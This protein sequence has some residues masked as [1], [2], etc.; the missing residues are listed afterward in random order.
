MKIDRSN[1]NLEKY[2]SIARPQNTA[3]RQGAAVSFEQE[4]IQKRHADNHLRMQELLKE[5]DKI[6]SQLNQALSIN[7]LMQYKKLVKNFLAEAINRAYSINH[8]RGRNRRGRT[9]LITIDVIDREIESLIDDFMKQRRDPMD[10]LDTL[11]KIRG[12]LV[13]LMA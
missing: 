3:V 7:K 1:K 10:I 6:S 9:M 11:D 8:E 4:L 2:G 5:I 13:D 12:M